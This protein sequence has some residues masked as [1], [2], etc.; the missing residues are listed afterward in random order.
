MLYEN[1]NY[2][3]DIFEQYGWTQK[4]NDNGLCFV[5]DNDF[6]NQFLIINDTTNNKIY[7]SYP[8]RTYTKYNYGVYIEPCYNTIYD[9]VSN[10]LDYLHQ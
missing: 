7:V 1:M 4:N 2:I 6:A 9:Y 10:I 3:K 5:K 8:L